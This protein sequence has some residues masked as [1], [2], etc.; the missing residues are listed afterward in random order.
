MSWL[1]VS[2]GV[3]PQSLEGVEGV[4]LA[5]GAVAITLVS[6]DDEPVL[7]PAPGETP[8]W[9]HVQVRSLLPLDVPIARL[10][11][12]LSALAAIPL[13]L[14]V[15]FVG[16]DDHP[17]AH[18]NFSVNEVFGGRIWLQPKAATATPSEGFEPA[19]LVPL[20]LE[21]GLAFGSGSHPTTRMCLDWLGKHLTAGARVLDFGCGSGILGIAAALLGARAVGVDHDPQAVMAS[22]DN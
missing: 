4:L 6:E 12:E 1:Q 20:R 10:R 3:T 14:E 5:H 2:L 11:D 18:T 19:D 17:L 22:K 15:D 8:L 7:E 13:Q 21:P 9:Q 16:P